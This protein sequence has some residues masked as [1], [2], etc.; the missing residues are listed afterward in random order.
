MFYRYLCALFK[1]VNQDAADKAATGEVFEAA[2]NGRILLV[3][4]NAVNQMVAGKLLTSMGLQTDI[5]EDGQQAI[6]KLTNTPYAYDLVL[7]DIQMPVM[8]GFTATDYIRNE[9]NLTMPICGLSANA[10]SEDY[11]RAIAHGMDNFIT[12]PI[13]IDKLKA[14]LEQY[15]S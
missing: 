2:F 11:N 7:M 15:L 9:L 3:E 4:D 10:M 12:K 14:V 6:D 8:D 13:E 1:V 5:A